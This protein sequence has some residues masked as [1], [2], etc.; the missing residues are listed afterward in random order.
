FGGSLRRDNGDAEFGRSSIMLDGTP[1]RKMADVSIEE[2]RR[3]QD[4]AAQRKR[5]LAAL[6][7]T[8]EKKG[9][10]VTGVGKT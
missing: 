1:R 5:V 7:Q 2:V 6:K 10:R 4:R 8:V 9:T 3:H